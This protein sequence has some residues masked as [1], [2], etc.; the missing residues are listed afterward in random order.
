MQ[1]VLDGLNE[2]QQ[3]AVVHVA[4]PLLI[5]AG[6]GSGKTRVLTHRIA[7]LIESGHAKPWQIM[8]VTFTNKAAKEMK[9]RIHKIVGEEG[10]D[11]TIGT[12]HSICVRL[13]RQ[14]LRHEGRA[15]FTIYDEG[16]TMTV[17]REA[18]AAANI[19]DKSYSPAA[20]RGAIS[21]AKNELVRAAQFEPKRHFD[22]IVRRVYI[23]Y[24]RR[25]EENNAFDF[26]DL[27]LRTVRHLQDNVERRRY[28]SNRYRFVSVDEYQDTN[29]AQYL[30]AKLIASEHCNLCVVG[31]SDQGIYSWRGANIRNILEF[32]ND[33]P[34]A[35]VVHLEQNYRSTGVILDAANRVVSQNR[36]RLP[37]N[38][39][40]EN[41]RGKPI[42]RKVAYDEEQEAEFV[43]SEI[44]RLVAQRETTIGGCA[45]LYRT[46]A[47]SRALEAAF[48]RDGT[49]YVLIGGVR[50]YERREIKDVLAYLRVLANPDDSVSLNRIINVP[51]RKI[52]ATTVQTLQA[53]ARAHKMSVRAALKHIADG[54]G[55]D[56]NDLSAQALR[57]LE[58]FALILAD[59]DATIAESNVY[60]MLPYLL[61]RTGYEAFVRDDTEEGEERWQNIQ[62]LRT[63]ALDY[64]ALPPEE[65]LASLLE[66]VALVSDVDK[67]EDDSEAVTLITL[68]AA[69]GLEFPVVFITGM[70]EGVFPHSRALQDTADPAGLEE[71]RRLAYVGVT[72]ARQLLYLVSAERR[73]LYGNAQ[74]NEPSRFLDA[75]PPHLMEIMGGRSP[76]S[77][78]RAAATSFDW[79][80]ASSKTG[81]GSGSPWARSAAVPRGDSTRAAFAEPAAPPAPAQTEPNFAAGER[82]QHKFFGVGTIVSSKLSNGDEEVVIEFTDKRG[83]KVRKTFMAGMASLEHL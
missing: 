6:A 17:V 64:A 35:V 78:V 54:H 43:V 40:T 50:F 21:S 9:E 61:Q 69:K 73:L 80:S 74:H 59:L 33:Y 49:P 18:M 83:A 16:D 62:E 51:S 39:W 25:L 81:S 24:E 56:L 30:F 2:Q 37:K 71:E 4:G 1:R 57:A 28:L 32:E 63:V 3:A 47:Q 45:V 23:E 19:S 27:I 41:A 20:V 53:W 26:D 58:G 72:R 79:S 55:A 67:I 44:R 10:R 70:E 68:H 60:D 34:E 15:A 12:F 31:D 13:L 5:H 7:H 76:R 8:A 14:E 82:V 46:N 22:E 36:Q 42:R 29:H 52:G 66:N 65:G 38:L 48:V 77:T 75:I 11:I